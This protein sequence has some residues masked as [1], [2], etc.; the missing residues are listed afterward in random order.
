MRPKFLSSAIFVAA[1]LVSFGA[2]AD[3]ATTSE[4]VVT[5]TRTSESIDNIIG[6]VTVITRE[7]IEHSQSQSVPDLL[8]DT[9]GLDITESGG[10]GKLTALYLRGTDPKHVL[11]LIDG[12]RIG[13]VTAGISQFEYLPIDQIERIEI[14]RGPRSSLYGADAIGGVI[15]IFTRNRGDGATFGV[16]TGSLNTRKANGDFRMHSGNA[17]LALSGSRLRTSGFNACKGSLTAGCFTIEPDDD[18]FRNT[19]GSIR[20]GYRWNDRA[21]VDVGA[22]YSAG[23]TDFDGSFTNETNFREFVPDLQAHI[24][25]TDTV[26]LTLHLGVSRDDQ[27]SLLNGLANGFLD[28]E[29]RSGTLQGDFVVSSEQKLTL[30]FDYLNDRVISDTPYEVRSRDNKAG[31]A[32]YQLG[33]A[34]QRLDASVRRDRNEQFGDHDTG[35]LGWKWAISDAFAVQAGWGNAFHAPTFNDLY[36]PGFSNPNLQPEKSRSIE[37]GIDGRQE[38]AGHVRSEQ[39]SR[40]WALNAYQT[41]IEQLIQLDSSFVPANIA[42]ARI[43]GIELTETLTGNHWELNASYS[44]TDPRNREPGVDFD[45][46]LPRRV[47]HSGL[48]SISLIHGDMRTSVAVRAQ[49]RRFDNPANTIALGSYVTVDLATEYSLTPQWKTQFKVGNLLNRD[50]Q[51][52]YLYNEAPRTFFVGIQYSPSLQKRTSGR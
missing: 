10:M 8:R 50:Y 24:R 41:D 30:G 20:A 9:A 6:S 37:F 31:F 51:T 40:Q 18:G 14:V 23:H 27:T 42:R 39:W 7:Q 28:T 11:V 17:W 19:S 22:L 15:Q 45:K 5:A 47:R 21:D 3:D 33:F 4:V 26:N 49:G 46:I 43:R 36:Y 48:L 16:G 2:L 12:I 32:E 35:N 44:Y 38:Y 25:P 1:T 13:S 34:N 29:Q 52:A